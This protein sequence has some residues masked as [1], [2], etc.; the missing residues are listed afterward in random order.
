MY[1]VVIA[2][3]E[4]R[5]LLEVVPEHLQTQV[6]QAQCHPQVPVRGREFGGTQRQRQQ[7]YGRGGRPVPAGRHLAHQ[8]GDTVGQRGG[9][10]QAVGT[11][12]GREEVRPVAAQSAPGGGRDPGRRAHVDDRVH[13]VA[14]PQL[15]QS[16]GAPAS[17]V[18]DAAGRPGIP[19][20]PVGAP[21]GSAAPGEGQD[22]AKGDG[23]QGAGQDTAKGGDTEGKTSGGD[24]AGDSSDTSPG[25]SSGS[26]TGGSSSGSAPQ[27]ARVAMT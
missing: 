1:R 4:V 25:S 27:A 7:P 12:Q 21:V 22:A 5:M 26:G 8:G 20:L 16:D 17:G 11:R 14:Q 3:H 6:L 24:S 13:G 9:V 15:P 2:D 10:R 19:G 23:A 18:P